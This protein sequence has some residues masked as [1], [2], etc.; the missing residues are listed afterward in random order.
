[1][2]GTLPE[3]GQTDVTV[4][5]SVLIVF[6][7]SMEPVSV[8][9]AIEIL[10]AINYHSIWAEPNYFLVLQPLEPLDFNTTYTVYIGTEATSE[11]GMLLEEG[12]KL[13]FTTRGPG[14]IPQVIE[15][16]P[17][18][19][20]TNALVGQPVEIVF[21]QPMEPASVEAAI[22]VSPAIDFAIFWQEDNTIAVLQPLASL[23]FNTTYTVDIGTE[24]MSADGMPL[25][26][27]YGFHF[28]TGI[29]PTPHV[30]GT[31]PLDGQAD[32][33]S[34]H[35]IQIA[36]DWPMEPASVEAALVVSPTMDY[37]T[38]WHEA[39]FVLRIEPTTPWEAN[40]TYT[41]EIGTEAMSIDG[42]PLE[43]RFSFS[44]T[45]GE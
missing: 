43:E 45:T 8:E 5:Q 6:D 16:L 10:P 30:L 33:P 37:T 14:D 26:E 4:S 9:A 2:I 7:Q 42:L 39:N 1:M 25:A 38:T 15:T 24:A 35:P 34:N 40:T 13:N 36:F 44:F 41:F 28:I 29:V 27:S 12:Y 22:V 23:E 18:D 17:L 31:L 11:A 32:I 19:G 3:Y 21:D 20:Q